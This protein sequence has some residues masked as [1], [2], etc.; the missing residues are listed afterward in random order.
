[1]ET[2][3]LSD[4]NPASM[5]LVVM[6]N[7]YPEFVDYLN[8]KYPTYSW[9]EKL[10]LYYNNLEYAPTC[11]ICGAPVKF[12]SLGRG[13]QQTCSNECRKKDKSVYDRVRET[14]IKHYG[15]PNPMA[16]ESI[17]DKIK[18]TCMERYGTTNGGWSE[19][20]QQKI[21]Q[22][23]RSRHGVDFPMQS[24]TIRNKSKET[25]K[26]K[27]GVE[28]NSQIESLKPTKNEKLRSYAKKYRQNNFQRVLNTHKE[29]LGLTE[30]FKYICACPHPECNRCQ[31]KQYI[32]TPDCYWWRHSVERCT[33]LSP[34]DKHQNKDTYIERFI[35]DILDA[36]NIEYTCNDR[37]ILKKEMDIYIPG[38]R[39]GIECNGCYWHSSEYKAPSYH[40]NKFKDAKDHGIELLQIWEDWIITK[41]EIV[42]SMI[43]S[44]IYKSPQKIGARQCVIKEVPRSEGY[45]F[46]DANHIQG[47]SQYKISYGLY[48]EDKLVSLITFGSKRGCTG[49]SAESGWE[50][51][52]FC[53]VLNTNV[54]GAASRLL[55]YFIKHH[56]VTSIYSYASCDISQGNLYRLLGFEST[57]KITESYWYIDPRTH[58]RYHRSSFTKDAIVKKGMRKDKNGWTESEVMRE[59]KYIKIYDSGQT[60]WTLNIKRNP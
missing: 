32:I 12:L 10:Y 59:F 40:I 5:R 42:R 46:L 22:S 36:N 20:A 55:K 8:Q 25:F 9:P 35:K 3:K 56:E 2:P 31:E 18:A 7:H 38:L 37:S 30:D 19:Q 21:K 14:N 16:L 34:E 15:V 26:Q 43:L 54:V 33:I 17:K 52:R 57:Q 44:R 13:Y 27:Y 45:A 53:N 47:K 60:K 48:Y 23:N 50:L 1:M 4:L 49:G 11:K 58:K 24:E 39:L 29:I 51:I 28:H 41:P 6:N